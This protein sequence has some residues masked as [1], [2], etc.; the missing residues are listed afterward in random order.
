[1]H[2]TATTHPA[3]PQL[4]GMHAGPPSRPPSPGTAYRKGTIL[5]SLHTLPSKGMYSMKRTCRGQYE[6]W[7]NTESVIKMTMQE[8]H[9]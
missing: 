3:D 1:M 6:A 5:L 2:A 4:Q 7:G 9:V 8:K